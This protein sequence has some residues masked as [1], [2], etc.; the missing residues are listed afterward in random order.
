[1]VPDAEEQAPSAGV[2]LLNNLAQFPSAPPSGRFDA[3]RSLF[4]AL[5]FSSLVRGS[6]TAK[7]LAR[8]IR[9]GAEGKVVGRNAQPDADD[10]EVSLLHVLVGNLMLSERERGEAIRRERNATAGAGA[11]PADLGGLPSS[12]DWTRIAVGYLSLLAQWLWDSPASVADLL[13]ESSNVQTLVQ[14]AAQSGGG[15][16]ALV[17]SLCALVLGVAYEF[18]P[19]DNAECV[20]RATMHPLL[21]SRIGTDQFAARLARLRDDVRIKETS[22][23]TFETVAAALAGEVGEEGIWFDWPFVEWLKN[24]FGMWRRTSAAWPPG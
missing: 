10:D 5:L 19:H 12:T 7:G 3:Y 24:N 20:T 9:F 22:P 16:D 11:P 1:M 14:P 13:S 4:S 23:D 2:L 6:E 18:A 15:V 21:V 17:A 8:E